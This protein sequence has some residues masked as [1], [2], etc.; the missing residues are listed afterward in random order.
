MRHSIVLT[1]PERLARYP[2]A[3][4]YPPHWV[5]ENAMGPNP[6][7]LAEW[8]AERMDLKPGMRVLDLGCGRAMTSIF[9]AER[10]GVQVCAADLWIDPEENWAR[11]CDAG[12]QQQVFPLR[13]NA[14]EPP[15]APGSFDALISLDAYHYFGTAATYPAQ[16]AR[17]VRPGGQLGV[18]VPCL[19]KDIDYA[20]P[21]AHL[22]A[23]RDQ[24]PDP[25]EFELIRSLNWWR[26]N[27]N[28]SEAVTLE[29]ADTQPD[30]WRYWLD[31][32]Y[33]AEGYH[34]CPDDGEAAALEADEGEY[35][36]LIRL[37]GRRP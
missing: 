8:L 20:A 36:G 12:L 31:F 30:G 25:E 2:L 27:W 16:A 7:W 29:C 33:A 34:N 17:Y 13:V 19:L 32:L 37:L 3:Q 26:A 23:W 22:A 6:L 18:V 4:E 9:L 28:E 21:P 14:D 10:F 35:L 5:C 15:Y 11:V 1:S 24:W